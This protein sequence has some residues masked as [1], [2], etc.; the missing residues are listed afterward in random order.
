M[1]SFQAM[2]AFLLIPGYIICTSTSTPLLWR[3]FFYNT[4]GICNNSQKSCAIVNAIYATINCLVCSASII[5]SIMVSISIAN[6][7]GKNRL[8]VLLVWLLVQ[9][10]FVLHH[11][12]LHIFTI[13]SIHQAATSRGDLAPLETMI[14]TI[15]LVPFT[16]TMLVSIGFF[17]PILLH[18]RRLKNEIKREKENARTPTPIPLM[19]MYT[20]NYN[21]Y[22]VG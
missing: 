14:I 17:I 16:V 15:V 19:P 7:N 12:L 22:I 1:A 6:A 5:T 2:F 21:S 4:P 20:N 18:Y 11:V 10:M 8:K 3:L 9:M 13:I